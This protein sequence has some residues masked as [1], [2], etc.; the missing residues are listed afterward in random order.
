MFLRENPWTPRHRKT[1]QQHEAGALSQGLIAV[2]S[3]IRDWVKGQVTAVECGIMTAD[4]VFL[5]HTVTPDGRTISERV[6]ELT[7]LPP[8]PTTQDPRP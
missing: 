1:K 7:L 5:A 6:N 3:I 2:N 8:P 4:T